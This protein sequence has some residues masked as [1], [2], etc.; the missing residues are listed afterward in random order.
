M[1]KPD[2]RKR[3]LG[4]CEDMR[5]YAE[6]ARRFMGDRT[7][8]EFT[9]DEMAQ[10]AVLRCIEIVGEAS[11]LVSC[12]T[13]NRKPEIP[14]TLIVGTRNILA[15]VYGGVDLG[16]IYFVVTQHLPSLL[17]NLA[18]LIAELEKEVKG[19]TGPEKS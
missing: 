12:E 10:A 15:H 17:E 5:V 19:T 7:L 8:E 1:S 2:L 6:K 16:K 9:A 14:W 4:K 3:D 18:H 13:R 11:R